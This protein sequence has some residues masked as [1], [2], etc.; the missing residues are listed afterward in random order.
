MLN[1][2]K[3]T[4]DLRGKLWAECAQTASMIENVSVGSHREIPSHKEF[5]NEDNKTIWNLRTFGEIGIATKNNKE[6]RSNLSNN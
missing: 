4:G 1:G 3:L 6:L 2:A 5:Y